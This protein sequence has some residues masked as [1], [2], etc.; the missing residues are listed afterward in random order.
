MGRIIKH[1][2]TTLLEPLFGHLGC[3]RC[4]NV[5]DDDD[6]KAESSWFLS[7]KPPLTLSSMLQQHQMAL[8]WEEG[9]PC[10]KS[11]VGTMTKCLHALEV[12][13]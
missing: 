8:I 12:S 5:M 7:L 11:L 1:F 13:L 2:P 3:V 4:H 10:E 6:T 9:W